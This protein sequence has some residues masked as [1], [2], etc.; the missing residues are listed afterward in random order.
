MS[1]VLHG[2]M[3]SLH[4]GKEPSCNSSAVVRFRPSTSA[5]VAVSSQLVLEGLRGQ[6]GSTDSP[7]LRKGG[8]TLQQPYEIFPLARAQPDGHLEALQ[9]AR[10]P[11][12]HDRESRDAVERAIV[13]GKVTSG[14][15]DHAGQ[16]QLVIERLAVVGNPDVGLVADDAG[17]ARE[18]ED[19]TRYHSGTMSSPRWRRH[20]A[21]CCSKA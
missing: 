13:G 3:G 10:A 9:V 2:A 11:V 15:A 16:F 5:A 14:L 12:V 4:G 18:L 8:Y 7:L 20:V 17:G 19:G 1:C 6:L 21:T